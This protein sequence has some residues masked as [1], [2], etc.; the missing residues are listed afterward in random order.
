MLVVVVAVYS[1]KTKTELYQA[2]RR[3][4]DQNQ[5]TS[6]QQS[7]LHLQIRSFQVSGPYVSLRAHDTPAK[8]THIMLILMGDK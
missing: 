7:R 4:K 2:H 5:L 3:W 8:C 1:S 6:M